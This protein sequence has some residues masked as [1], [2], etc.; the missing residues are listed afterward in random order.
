MLSV[1]L[2]ALVASLGAF[3][4]QLLG[5]HHDA[6]GAGGGG[7]HDAAHGGG[8]QAAGHEASAWTLVA[9]VRFWSFALLAFGLV[10][11]LLTLLGLAG[12]ALG[13]GLASVAGLGS[14]FFATSVIRR[15]TVR[16]ATSHA[17]ARDVVGRV[18]RVV[19]PLVPGGLGKVRVEV[20][21]TQADYVARA[22]EALETGEAV[23]VEDYAE[24]A[25]V[26]SRAPREL[27]R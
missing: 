15:L 14:G 21:G 10:G 11:T 18:G 6:G 17:G 16:P 8:D 7:G 25:V 5:G 4:I 3:A 20:K 26:V 24:D 2:A 22:K 9:S 13:A 19:V 12:G 1:Y 27:L 23:L